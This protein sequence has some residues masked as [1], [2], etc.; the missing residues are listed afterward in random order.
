MKT[1]IQIADPILIEARDVATQ[2]STTLR[3]LVEEGLRL[4]IAQRR[5]Q[6][7]SFCLRRATFRGEGLQP[8]WQHASW[9]QLRAAIYEDH[10]G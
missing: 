1:T 2:S 7:G 10:G 9:E 8:G 4:V 5:A 3:A 6:G